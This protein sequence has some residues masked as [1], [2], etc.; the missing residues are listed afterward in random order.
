M[1]PTRL[2]AT[3]RSFLAHVVDIVAFAVLIAAA[4]GTSS[5]ALAKMGKRELMY[6]DHQHDGKSCGQCRYFAPDNAN[7]SIG[8][9]EIVDGTISRDGWC[10]AFVVKGRS[11]M[12]APANRSASMPAGTG[13]NT[14]A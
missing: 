1:R 10:M 12:T 3:R 5:R 8:S 11:E 7:A 9:C 13:R 4:V 2:E 14:D 6:Q